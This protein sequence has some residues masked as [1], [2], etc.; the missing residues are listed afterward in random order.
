M[1]RK[2]GRGFKVTE[3]KLRC[4]ERYG[5]RWNGKGIKEETGEKGEGRWRGT[6]SGRAQAGS[7]REHR[8]PAAVPHAA[9]SPA[10]ARE[11]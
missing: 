3:E 1:W 4:K 9:A 7:G 2:M 5:G 6:S 8:L 10:A 11:V